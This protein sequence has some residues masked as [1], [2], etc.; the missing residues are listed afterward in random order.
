MTKQQNDWCKVRVTLYQLS[1]NQPSPLILLAP[2]SM[3]HVT[4][5]TDA[6]LTHMT[7]RSKNATTH[8]GIMAQDA[9]C[10]R[11]KKEEIEAEKEMKTAKK[12]A[13]KK[14]KV[15]N[16]AQQA[17][18]KAYIAQL[19]FGEATATAKAEKEIPRQ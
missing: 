14:K 9:L 12:E 2:A 13:I 3:P 19:E 1:S 7:T 15:A 4:S 16:E 5:D 6:G 8:P 10:A 17:A 18:G 11:W